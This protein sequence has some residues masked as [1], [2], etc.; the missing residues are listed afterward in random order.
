MDFARIVR[1]EFPDVVLLV[2]GGFRARR[3][4]EDAL[5]EGGCDIV[6]IARPATILPRLP[7]EI[8]FNEKE[9]SDEEVSLWLKPVQGWVCGEAYPFEGCGCGD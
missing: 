1:T 6:G 5:R 8:L 3:G 2:T 9:V 7:K 4:M